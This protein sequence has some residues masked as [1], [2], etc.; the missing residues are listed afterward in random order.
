METYKSIFGVQVSSLGNVKNTK[1][2]KGGIYNGYRKV[3]IKID[4]KLKNYSVHRLVGMAFLPNPENKPEINHKNGIKTDN[5]VE[6]LEW[7]T[8]SENQKHAIKT[9]LMTNPRGTFNKGRTGFRS[10]VGKKCTDG[11]SIFGSVLDMARKLKIPGSTAQWRIDNKYK[12]YAFLGLFIFLLACTPQRQEV[13]P[14]QT[15]WNYTDNSQVIIAAEGA[16]VVAKPENTVTQ[17]AE[18]QVSAEATQKVGQSLFLFWLGLAA[19]IV[20]TAGIWFL[21]ARFGP[22]IKGW[23]I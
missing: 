1:I 8:K 7:V 10:N 4:G 13:S 23:L 20:L 15:V 16:K 18:P 17:V 2:L 21:W 12:K 5:R 22:K 11:K 3:L 9:G 19:G 14:N 6:N